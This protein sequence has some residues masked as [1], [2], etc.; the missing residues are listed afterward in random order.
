MLYISARSSYTQCIAFFLFSSRLNNL[1][2]TTKYTFE[3]YALTE[4]G[5]GR[6]AVA[7]IQSGVEPVLPSPPTR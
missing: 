1:K 3:V 4:V 6:A 2:P 7:A 5:R